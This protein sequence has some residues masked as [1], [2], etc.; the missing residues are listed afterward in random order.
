MAPKKASTGKS[1]ATDAASRGVTT[2]S[3]DQHRTAS[4]GV[5]PLIREEM[6]PP[7]PLIRGGDLG[8]TEA[9]N[10]GRNEAVEGGDGPSAPPRAPTSRPHAGSPSAPPFRR[11]GETS[12]THGTP[13]ASRRSVPG[14]S[15]VHNRNDALAMVRSPS[16]QTRRSSR[17]G[18]RESTRFLSFCGC[19]LMHRGPGP[20]RA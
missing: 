13:T 1:A 14:L 4:A 15:G 8:G 11:D 2:H 16:L 12:A 10:N 6:P 7:P 9:N 18:M 3:Q 17:P 20:N 19:A 5:A